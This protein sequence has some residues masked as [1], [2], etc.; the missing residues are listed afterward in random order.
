MGDGTS[1][2]VR[3]LRADPDR[4]L[5]VGLYDE[6]FVPSF[7]PDE[8]DPLEA[9]EDG[10]TIDREPRLSVAVAVEADGTVVGGLG[11]DRFT[12][13]GVLLLGYLAVRPDRRG[14]GVG[15]FLLDAVGAEWYRDPAVVLALGELHDPRHE[16]DLPGEDALGRL[17]FYGRVGAR[18][19]AVPFV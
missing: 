11:A 19:L 7:Q 17:R 12:S 14:R 18:L 16:W 13:C 1:I 8:L 6:V 5:L 15:T 10:L 2:E 3:D 4:S 9:F